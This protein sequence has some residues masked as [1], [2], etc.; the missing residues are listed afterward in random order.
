MTPDQW[1]K[2]KTLLSQAAEL[3]NE[4]RSMFV[5]SIADATIKA[6]LRRL[7]YQGDNDIEL[8][9]P[10]FLLDPAE[11]RELEP[12]RILPERFKVSRLLGRGGMGI[13]Y[14][15]EDRLLGRDVALKLISADFATNAAAREF[16]LSEARTASTLNHPNVCTI[17][18]FIEAS[19][20]LIL[21][22]ELLSGMTLAELLEY[23]K[24]ELRESIKLAI[25]IADGLAAAHEKGIVHRDIKPSN[26]FVTRHG[27]P[28]I[29]DFGIAMRVPL[30]RAKETSE[31]TVRN[32]AR[33]A[34]AGTRAYMSP[35]QV[36]GENALITSDIFSL[37]VVLWEMI[38]GIHPF[39][40]SIGGRLDDAILH[41][42]PDPAGAAQ[43]VATQGLCAILEKALSKKP[44]F[45]HSDARELRDDLKRVHKDIRSDQPAR[46]P[47]RLAVLPFRNLISPDPDANYFAEGFAED[48]TNALGCLGIRVVART[49]ASRFNS[50][51]YDLTQLRTQLG[52]DL[53]LCG[54]IRRAEGRLRVV[55]ELVDVEDGVRVWSAS[56]DRVIE[57]L[58]SVQDDIVAALVEKLRV[59][60]H[61]SGQ[62]VPLATPRNIDAYGYFLK[63]R[64]FCN[65][66]TPRDLLQSIDLFDNALLLDES[67]SSAWTGKAQAQLLLGIYGVQPPDLCFPKA[68][69][70]ANRALRL[71]D[72]DG[73][74]RAVLGAVKAV[75]EWDWTGAEKAFREALAVG[76]DSTV[77][78][79][80]SNYCLVPL[81]RLKEAQ[82]QIRR[83]RETDPVS[84][85][86]FASAG[87]LAMF[88]QDYEKAISECE[89]ALELD[90]HFSIGHY[91]LG[92]ALALGGHHERSI[93]ELETA[94]KL[95]GDSA[96]VISILGRTLAMAGD[97]TSALD[98]L[99]ELKGRA[100]QY[101][102]SPFLSAQILIGLSDYDRGFELLEEAV[103]KHA[104]E[105]IWIDVHPFFAP[106]RNDVRFRKIL[107]AMHL[108][109]PG[110]RL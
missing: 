56:Y 20:H 90:P 33:H 2:I 105:L 40:S 41:A 109:D 93:S 74:A 34:I 60:F 6:E 51:H 67:F 92:Q 10:V 38:T 47:A 4:Q 107:K 86:I 29:L 80:Y 26:I 104:A 100:E 14:Q 8:L 27:R 24:P 32:S 61:V 19:G 50:Q 101:Y 53:V 52:I 39:A 22:M 78:Q 55:A 106:L 63:A 82:R 1:N 81:G 15:A 66:R 68:E 110:C 48:L 25:E 45:R 71:K 16:F 37:G 13:V 99:A 94:R 84:L 102:V 72:S 30:A 46:R 57:D 97:R 89:G 9:E 59:H 42:V 85:A 58:F 76:D 65:K 96:E 54:S 35:E 75:Y 95:S 77:R 83:A 7:I 44:E 17:F 91:F 88:E 70:S 49:S 12:D 5:E 79:W 21:V 73:G 69:E 43:L 87:L 103:I 28:K 36:R 11:L 31:R 3:S 98:R 18:D 64:F 62:N 23:Q 108:T